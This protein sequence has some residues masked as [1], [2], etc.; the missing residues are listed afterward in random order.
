[1]DVFPTFK[2]GVVQAAPAWLDREA[3]TDKACRLIEEAADADVRLLAFPEA[4]LPGFPGGSSRA[5]G[6]G[7]SFF[8]ELYANSVEIPSPT[9][10]RLCRAAKEAGMYVVMGTDERSGE[11]PLSA[12]N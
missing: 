7:N 12:P 9:T 8:A 3:T 1:M 11:Q 6:W 4:W 5:P 10:D 2:A